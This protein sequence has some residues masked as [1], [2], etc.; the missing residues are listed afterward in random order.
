M[1]ITA[2]RDQVSP[3]AKRSIEGDRGN[4]ADKHS[5]NEGRYTLDS[6]R[7]AELV[8]VNAGIGKPRH[9]RSPFLIQACPDGP[10]IPPDASCEIRCCRETTST[11]SLRAASR[12]C[13]APCASASQASPWGIRDATDAT[14][15]APTSLILATTHGSGS[16]AVFGGPGHGPGHGIGTCPCGVPHQSS[17]APETSRAAPSPRRPPRPQQ[18]HARFHSRG[19]LRPTGLRDRAESAAD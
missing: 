16:G 8:D 19:A 4:D 1:P 13:S 5:E 10:G 12:S 14:V 7:G 9:R 11:Q 6:L 15:N 18:R 17:T 3:A 2:S